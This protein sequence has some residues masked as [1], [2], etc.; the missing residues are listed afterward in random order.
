MCQRCRVKKAWCSFNKGSDDGG[1]TESTTVMELLQDISSRLAHLEDKVEHIVE[2]VEDLMD[3]Y[4]PDHDVKYPDDLPSKS[5]MAEFEASQ[6][7]LRKTRDIY[8]EVLRQ[9]ATQR[10][11][12]DMAVIK[13]KGLQSLAEDM[14]LGMD[15]LYEILN[16][17]FWVGTV[18][19]TGLHEQML[20]RNKFLQARR[21]FYNAH[22]HRK[23]WQL[24][25]RLL[26]GQDGYWVED[27]DEP[28]DLEEEV[29]NDMVPGTDSVG[30][31]ELDALIKMPMPDE[32]PEEEVEKELQWQAMARR[33][34]YNQERGIE[35]S[36]GEMYEDLES[37]LV[38]EEVEGVSMAGP[39]GTEAP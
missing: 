16:K 29:R 35:E 9:M 3:D 23:E 10:L 17:S 30:I 26:K 24:W 25:K 4:H 15:D 20:A 7:E 39:S 13:V 28:L 38:Q 18:G 21:E 31:P 36:D 14:P 22:G 2:R 5:M 8:S 12:R 37:I 11:D 32:D 34:A 33:R 1:S 6:L 27:S 19:V